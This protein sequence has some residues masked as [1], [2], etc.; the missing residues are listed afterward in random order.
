MPGCGGPTELIH[1]CLLQWLSLGFHGS[2]LGHGFPAADTN[3]FG[4]KLWVSSTLVVEF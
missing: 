2:S 1:I 3:D 4:A